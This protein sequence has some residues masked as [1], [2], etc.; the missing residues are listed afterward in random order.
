MKTK[1]KRRPVDPSVYRM[2]PMTDNE[3]VSGQISRGEVLAG[4]DAARA[5][6]QRIEES[7]GF[8]DHPAYGGSR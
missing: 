2:K 5:I 4:P 3:R 1:K 7:G 8:W 6:A